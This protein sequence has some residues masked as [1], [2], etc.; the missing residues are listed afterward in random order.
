MMQDSFCSHY[1]CSKPTF[2][3]IGKGL[4]SLSQSS[5]RKVRRCYCCAATG[6]RQTILSHLVGLSTRTHSYSQKDQFLS[7]RIASELLL[8]CKATALVT[9]CH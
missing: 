7:S 4:P 8:T 5:N 2:L 1:G 3:K 9:E 6:A